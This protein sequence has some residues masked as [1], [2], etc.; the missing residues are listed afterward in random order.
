MGFLT[1][2]RVVI[3][4]AFRRLWWAAPLADFTPKAIQFAIERRVEKWDS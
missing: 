3:G 1:S 2:L 4:N